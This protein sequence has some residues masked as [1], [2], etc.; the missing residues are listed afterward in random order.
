MRNVIAHTKALLH[1]YLRLRDP[2]A[3]FEIDILATSSGCIAAWLCLRLYRNIRAIA[4][5]P[6]YKC[7]LP[8]SLGSG[9]YTVVHIEKVYLFM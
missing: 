8:P 4:G 6:Q 2:A 1:M 5:A 3:V 9:Q 7:I